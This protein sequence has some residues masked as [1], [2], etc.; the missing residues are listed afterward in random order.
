MLL[1]FLGFYVER[2]SAAQLMGLE[3]SGEDVGVRV[4]RTIRTLQAMELVK[5]SPPQL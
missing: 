5:R 4:A 1:F 2:L 3:Q